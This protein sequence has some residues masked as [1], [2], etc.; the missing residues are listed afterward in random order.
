MK[1]TLKALSIVLKVITIIF[2]IIGAIITIAMVIVAKPVVN[3]VYDVVDD[4][5]NLDPDDET[6]DAALMAEAYRRTISDPSVKRSKFI[7]AV[8]YGV[9]KFISFVA[10][11]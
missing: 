4:C 8:C 2:S 9:G 11:L 10:N 5:D 3:H 6:Q 7:N 1:N